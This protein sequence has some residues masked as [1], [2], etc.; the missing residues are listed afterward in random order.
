MLRNELVGL[1]MEFDFHSRLVPVDAKPPCLGDEITPWDKAVKTHPV[2]RLL[3][4]SMWIRVRSAT[5][6]YR[7]FQSFG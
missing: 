7:P 5:L 1:K 4:K 6:G 2:V 3:Q